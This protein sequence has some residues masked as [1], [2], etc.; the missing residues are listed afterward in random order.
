MSKVS[1]QI[2]AIVKD[3][4]Q[5][6]VDM[7]REQYPHIKVS[8][9]TIKYSVRGQVAG[10]AYPTL[11]L[12]DFNAVLLTENLESFKTRTIPHELAHIIA[13]QLGGKGHDRI[14]KNI[15][16]GFGCEASRCHNYDVSNA[17]VRNVKRYE[18]KCACSTHQVTSI[19]HN[20]MVKK[21]VVYTC[22]KCG[23]KIT[24]VGQV[25]P[26]TTAPKQII[27]KPNRNAGKTKKEQALRIV[28]DTYGKDQSRR[29]T[30]QCLM[31]KLNMTDKGAATYFY[32]AKKELGL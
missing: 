13:R 27:H 6:Y 4:L 24:L 15:M 16:I 5:S 8:M 11:N 29:A 2:E 19:R 18:Y 22:V 28:N 3:T 30:I 32:N 23:T 12:V 10:K 25:Q 26:K 20:K 17:Q 7:A 14:W 1:S 21:G 31:E 9:P